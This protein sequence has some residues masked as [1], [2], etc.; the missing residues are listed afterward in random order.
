MR[1]FTDMMGRQVQLPWP[2][3][4]IVSLVPSQTELLADLGL[5]AEVLGITK[6]CV[7]PGKWFRNK[8]KVGGTKQLHLN[9]IRELQPDLIIGNKEENL[10]EQVEEL[11]RE[12][13][14]WM[15][16]ITDF[17]SALT[18]IEEVGELLDRAVQANQLSAEI[19]SAFASLR[20]NKP[21]VRA[22]YFIWRQP[23]MVAG[24]DTFIHSMMEMAGFENVFGH[25]TR[26]PEVGAADLKTAAPEVLLLSSEPYPFKEKHI[27]EF[28]AAL[29]N[30]RPLLVNGEMFSWYGIR[31]LKA[32]GYFGT[33]PSS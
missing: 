26:Y 25:R 30:C 24:G 22:A 2:P 7:H 3:K 33:L 12:F 23:W 28:S 14:V 4:R 29:S 15:S 19:H 20:Q 10:K 16:D 18:M 8:Q 32:A 27:E 31:M 5:E 6:F 17:E 9:R 13:P 11:A 1:L 21:K